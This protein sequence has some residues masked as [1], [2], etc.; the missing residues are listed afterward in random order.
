MSKRIYGSLKLRS[1]RNS[2]VLVLLLSV[3]LVSAGPL[4]AAGRVRISL[5]AGAGRTGGGSYALYWETGFEPAI[6]V[7]AWKTMGF[8]I[9]GIFYPAR[10]WPSAPRSHPRSLAADAGFWKSFGSDRVPSILL[11]GFS[12]RAGRDP[13]GGDIIAPGVHA[14]FRQELWA[15]RN[16]GLYGQGVL[17]FWFG[18]NVHGGGD[19][20]PSLTGGFCLRF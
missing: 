4:S 14:G 18:G 3:L 15:G 7:G 12:F 9:S 16:V 5:G 19:L 10:S 8:R 20:S 6:L 17:R 2:A 13:D 11:F 1:I